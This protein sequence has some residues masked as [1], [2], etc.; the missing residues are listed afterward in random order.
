MKQV[1]HNRELSIT[2]WRRLLEQFE[3][4][5]LPQA[6]FAR[7]HGVTAQQMIYWRKRVSHTEPRTVRPSPQI[8]EVSVAET[9]AKTQEIASQWELRFPSGLALRLPLSASVDQLF[10][11]VTRWEQ[12]AC[13]P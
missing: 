9:P 7:Q 8:V 5:E 13:S 2:Q 11:L 3:Q 4:S 6:Q 1:S 10:A 12:R